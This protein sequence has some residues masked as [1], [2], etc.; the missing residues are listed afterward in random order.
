MT[1]TFIPDQIENIKMACLEYGYQFETVDEH[2]NYLCRVRKGERFQLFGAS[3]ISSYP[4]NSATSYN[5]SLD[6]AFTYKLLRDF[7]VPVPE[8]EYF[9]INNQLLGLRSSGKDLKAAV[10]Y[11]TDFGFPLMAKPINGSRGNYVQPVYDPDDL[12]SHLGKMAQ[13]FHAAVLQELLSGIEYRAFV[14]DNETKFIYK[15]SALSR[16]YDSKQSFL[17]DLDELNL[18]R[19]STGLNQY[20]K[21]SGH[22]QRILNRINENQSIDFGVLNISSNQAEISEVSINIPAVIADL[23]IK[24]AEALQLRVFA[25]DFVS[26]Q[27]KIEDLASF[28]VLEVNG[29]PMLQALKSVGRCDLVLEIWHEIFHKIFD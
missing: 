1:N 9:F 6:K 24:I 16:K 26:P 22:I 13:S 5:I 27:K 10:K 7:G 11:A 12:K 29:N 3:F 21:E 23:G 18:K 14:L 15:K 28:C 8:G 19:K 4:L 25:Y 2:S 17:N 20:D